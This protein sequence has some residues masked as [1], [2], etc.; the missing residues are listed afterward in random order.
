[1]SQENKDFSNEFLGYSPNENLE[2]KNA[3]K[4]TIWHLYHIE[5]HDRCICS[6]INTH[7]FGVPRTQAEMRLSATEFHRLLSLKNRIA[8]DLGI[9]NVTLASAKRDTERFGWD[10]IKKEYNRVFKDCKDD[11]EEKYNPIITRKG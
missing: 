3:Y 10:T 6:H 8:R 9:S 1:M 5:T 7:G 4:L 2:Y 11:Y